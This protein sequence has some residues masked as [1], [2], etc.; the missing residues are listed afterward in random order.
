[1]RRKQGQL[2]PL[3]TDILGCAAALARAGHLHFHG[4]ALAKKLRDESEARSLTAHGTLYKALSRLEEAGLLES[5]W[6]DASHEDG[7]PR[8]RLYSLT[9]KGM[10]AYEAAAREVAPRKASERWAT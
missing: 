9:P 8:R 1:M 3:E 4:F 6:D 7:R 5:R 10:Q 2:V